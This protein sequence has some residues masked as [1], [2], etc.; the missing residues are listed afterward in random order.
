MG[1]AFTLSTV[2]T[3]S[4]EQVAEEDPSGLHFF[5]LYFYEDRPSGVK[6]IR[7]AE[8]QGY[9]ALIVTTDMSTLGKKI[10]HM[11]NNFKLPRHL[12]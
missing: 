2:A 6:L 3:S 11:R 5:Q 7:R 12:K 10:K 1:T 9:K 4:I 8:Q